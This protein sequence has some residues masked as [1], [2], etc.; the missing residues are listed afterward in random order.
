MQRAPDQSRKDRLA[1]ALKENLKRRKAQARARATGGTL[2]DA[3]APDAV[4]PYEPENLPQSG[5][6]TAPKCR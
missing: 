4:L 6:K 5:L 1:Q 2:P 3:Q